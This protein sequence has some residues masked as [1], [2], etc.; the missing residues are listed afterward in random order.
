MNWLHENVVSVHV[1]TC[2]GWRN[3]FFAR[4][5]YVVADQWL[6]ACR[7][8]GMMGMAM[9]NAPARGGMRDRE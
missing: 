4:M 1:G 3:L 5:C 6:A 2:R 8:A 7:G 9:F